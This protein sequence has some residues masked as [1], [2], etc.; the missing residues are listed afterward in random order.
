MP[1]QAMALM[2]A[3][4][5]GKS[6]L[7]IALA[8]QHDLCIITCDSMQ[9]Y[10]GLNI[11]TAK[12]S[13]EE[14]NLVRHVL[15]DCVDIDEVWDAQRW[16]N[17]ARD[18][19]KQENERGK[20]PL[21]VGGTGMYLRALV[22]GFAVI[23]SIDEHVRCMFEAQQLELGT[24]F[25]HTQLQK[26]DPRLASRLEPH[27]SQ[28]ILRGLCVFESTGKAL[29]AWHDEQDVKQKEAES[30]LHCPTFVLEMPRAI[31][32]QR[33]ASRFESMMKQGWLEEVLWLKEQ[34]VKDNHPVM[35]AVG[36]RQ[37]LNHLVGDCSLEQ[38]VTDGITATRRYAKRQNTWF[39]NQTSDAQ[40]GEADVI[41]A[42][43]KEKITQF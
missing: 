34:Q 43:M 31:L 41:L 12:P 36:Y 18:M 9:V 15:L 42:A 23:P 21:I 7:A 22:Q 10:R 37:L 4:G 35:R 33:L 38:A 17:M 30:A 24:P 2:G 29:S 3:T 11:G 40:R 1:L 6:A 26:V 13:Q 20:V 39:S 28:R 19:I 25:L 16:A 8:Q 14:Q 27:D 32:R 5:T